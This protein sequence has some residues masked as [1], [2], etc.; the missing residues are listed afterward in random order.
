MTF[1]LIRGSTLEPAKALVLGL[2]LAFGLTAC[3]G[4]GG[5][6][7]STTPSGPRLVNVPVSFVVRFV[8]TTAPPTASTARSP[9]YISSAIASVDFRLTAVSP[10]GGGTYSG[11][12][13]TDTLIPLTYGAG[14]CSLVVTVE[15]CTATSTAP[16]PATNTWTIY[17][18]ATA[19]PTVGTTTPLSIYAAD[20]Q[21]I[22]VAG[23]NN[24][25]VA[26]WGVPATLA[27]SPVSASGPANVALS[28]GSALTTSVQVKDAGGATLIGGN[29][30]ASP[31]GTAG[32][33]AFTGCAAHLTPTP[34]TIAAANPTALGAG[35]I[36]IAY[37]GLAS[38][39]T[40]LC[41]ATAPGGLTATYSV[42]L[43]TGTGNVGWTVT[44]VNRKP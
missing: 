24:L 43:A 40:I 9:R 27:F 37:D 38:A 35:S 1:F 13:N 18:Y 31:T 4:G 19:T 22:T 28:G 33:V 30:F 25:T 29:N 20:S 2:G 6:G 21:A 10:T 14:N 17:T 12:L 15:T 7:G 5:G 34:T 41:N 23:P 42:I 3:G 26:T 36:S 44:D 8:P 11:A 16:A 32:N 39:G